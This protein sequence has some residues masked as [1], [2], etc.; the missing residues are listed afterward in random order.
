MNTSVVL[1]GSVKI[2][3]RFASA[4]RG[5]ILDAILLR[6]NVSANQNGEVFALFV[7]TKLVAHLNKSVLIYFRNRR[8]FFILNYCGT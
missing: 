6:G 7:Y 5:V 2:A 3:R 4:K 8:L 1:D